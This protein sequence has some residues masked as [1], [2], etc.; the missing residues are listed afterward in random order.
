MYLSVQNLPTPPLEGRKARKPH[1]SAEQTRRITNP[2]YA[3]PAGRTK[4]NFRDLFRL[5][6]FTRFHYYVESPSAIRSGRALHRRSV[7]FNQKPE[8]PTRVPTRELPRA[9]NSGAQK[10]ATA[11]S[12]GGDG[13][14]GGG[15]GW[16]APPGSS[17]HQEAFSEIH[18]GRTA[19]RLCT[20]D[21]PSRYVRGLGGPGALRSYGPLRDRRSARVGVS[22]TPQGAPDNVG[23]RQDP[24]HAR[25]R[26]GRPE[27][28]QVALWP[29]IAAPPLHTSPHYLTAAAKYLRSV[30]S[31]HSASSHEA[32][33]RRRYA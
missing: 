8:V 10:D 5:S 32:E 7:D 26:R 21:R 31:S 14:G 11:I 18:Q 29:K 27:K 1:N 20:T 4:P 30:S 12:L 17:A 28:L 33:S 2:Y 22:G 3:T 15:C 23:E 24:T 16:E 25:A 19:R 6:G 9:G 13:A